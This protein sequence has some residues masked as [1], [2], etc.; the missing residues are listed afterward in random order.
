MEDE[1]TKVK[2]PSEERKVEPLVEGKEHKKDTKSGTTAE[3]FVVA[4]AV[5]RSVVALDPPSTGINDP[6]GHITVVDR[7]NNEALHSHNLNDLVAPKVTETIAKSV[8]R[9]NTLA[10]TRGEVV[11]DLKT[12]LCSTD[13]GSDEPLALLLRTSKICKPTRDREQLS[14]AT[15]NKFPKV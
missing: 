14:P 8:K 3:I 6:M 4:S 5:E 15:Q 10:G 9:V 13:R 12:T 7:G 2:L 11:V 1:A